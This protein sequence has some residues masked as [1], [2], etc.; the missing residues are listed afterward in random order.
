MK[1]IWLILDPKEKFFLDDNTDDDKD[2]FP[3]ITCNSEHWDD[4]SDKAFINS[5]FS[6]VNYKHPSWK[7]IIQFFCML[8]N[9][10][11]YIKQLSRQVVG[12][13]KMINLKD[14]MREATS[15][16]NVLMLWIILIWSG[17]TAVDKLSRLSWS[18]SDRYEKAGASVL[19]APKLGSSFT[20]FS[21]P[22]S[23]QHY[24]IEIYKKVKT[25]I[26]RHPEDVICEIWN[27]I[28][29]SS[30]EVDTFF[31]LGILLLTSSDLPLSEVFRSFACKSFFSVE[32]KKTKMS[33]TYKKLVGKEIATLYHSKPS[34]SKITRVQKRFFNYHHLTFF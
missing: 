9:A 10:L 29:R 7:K 28:R 17:G 11:K 20:I 33:Y 21:S 6:K 14:F 32:R 30:V 16:I 18:F 13:P 2:N 23:I 25:N 4:S 15:E 19:W 26:K 24:I 8:K 31:L 1:I 27:H 12:G 22:E 34:T 3:Q 5:S